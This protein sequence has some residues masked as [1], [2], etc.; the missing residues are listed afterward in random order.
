MTVMRAQTEIDEEKK[1]SE[2]AFQRWENEG[3]DVPE[4]EKLITIT[5]IEE[6]LIA[7]SEN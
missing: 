3:G 2:K 4:I 7:E 1:L 5:V 6:P